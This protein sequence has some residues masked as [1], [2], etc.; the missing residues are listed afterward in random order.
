MDETGNDAETWE[1]RD[2]SV[3]Y[4]LP[5]QVK[6]ENT[7]AGDDVVKGVFKFLAKLTYLYA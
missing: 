4:E 6:Q 3:G 1:L 7:N 5:G 2:T